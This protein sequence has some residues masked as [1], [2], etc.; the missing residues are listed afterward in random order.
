MLAGSLDLEHLKAFWPFRPPLPPLV[1]SGLRGLS[2]DLHKAA[3]NYYWHGV[4][5]GVLAALIAIACILCAYLV[6]AKNIASTAKIAILCTLISLLLWYASS[7]CRPMADGQRP[8]LPATPTRD[9][10]ERKR[11]PHFASDTSEGAVG[12]MQTGGPIAPDGKT[13]VACDI[14]I[15]LRAKNTGGTDGAGLCVFTSIMHSARWQ[16]EHRLWDFQ[17][18]MK[19]ERGGGYPQKVDAMVAK[20]GP[21]TPYLQY[22]GRDPSILMTA[23]KSGRAPGVTYNGHDPHYRGSIAHMVN[24]VAYDQQADQVAILDNNFIGENQLVWM[25][26]AEFLQRWTGGKAGSGWAV[27]LLAPPPPPPPKN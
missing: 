18:K 13:Q 26:A 7:V 4:S 21:G 1:S 10:P 17:A 3:Q 14:P 5:H 12:K 22:T 19:Q 15:E 16:N 8:A 9:E 23:L 11:R 2:D 25:S 27:I 6:F 24:L 20:Y